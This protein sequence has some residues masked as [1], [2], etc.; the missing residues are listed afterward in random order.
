MREILAIV[1][2]YFTANSVIPINKYYGIT[3]DSQTPV[4]LKK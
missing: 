3:K 4:K 2:K 1:K